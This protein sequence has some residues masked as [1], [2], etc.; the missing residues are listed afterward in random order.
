[1]NKWIVLLGACV[2]LPLAGFAEDLLAEAQEDTVAE[3]AEAVPYTPEE[4]VE[5]SVAEEETPETGAD[6][7]EVSAENRPLRFVVILPERIDHIWYWMLYSD[8]SQHIVQSAVE[9]A[10]VRAG[11][12]VIDLNAAR[13][14]EVGGD[15]KLLASM[16]YGLQAGRLLEAD[17]LITGQATAVKASEGRAY[18]VNVIR[19]Q[20]E[21]SARIVRISDG[22]II[23]V[24]DASAQEGGQS[25]QAAGQN[26]LKKAGAQ[27]A[28]KIARSARLLVEAEESAR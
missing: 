17:Y 21:V 19:T 8:Q 18:G 11:L 2:V 5:E 15:L 9:K 14:P 3:I 16:A 26:A 12:E 24:E 20:A 1:M 22:K 28:G 6:E 13:L 10:L 27:I 23:T 4:Q 25:V 7:P